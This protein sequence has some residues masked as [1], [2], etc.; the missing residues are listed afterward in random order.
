MP[1]PRIRSRSQ[2]S[3]RLGQISS[4]SRSPIHDSG[5]GQGQ[6]ESSLTTSLD[7][8]RTPPPQEGMVT[9][10]SSKIKN[11]VL[12]ELQTEIQNLRD[13]NNT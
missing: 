10:L 12:E 6:G 9:N 11:M 8:A 1:I 7:L 4:R 3:S 5:G 13:E 2:E